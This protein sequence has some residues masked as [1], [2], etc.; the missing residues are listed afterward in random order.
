MDAN[1]R[2]G[3]VGRPGLVTAWLG[4]VARRW[5]WGFATFA[6]VMGAAVGLLFV[7]RPV[8]RAEAKLRLSDP[9]AMAGVS[10]GG[11]T[12]SL[13]RQG[14][15]PIANDMQLMKS[16]TLREQVIAENALHVSVIAPAGWHRDSLFVSLAASRDTRKATYQAAYQADGRIAVSQI[17]P[18]ETPVGTFAPGEPASFEG[19]TAVFAQRRPAAPESFEIVTTPFGDAVVALA[20]KLEASRA[21]R[22]ANVLDLKV[23][24]R[25]PK[26]AA[27]ALESMLR[28]FVASRTTL[29]QR[30]SGETVDS[31]RSVA[32]GN[33]AELA[34]AESRLEA[35][36]RESGVIAPD[37][38]ND[39]LVERYSDVVGAHETAVAERDAVTAALA[40]VQSAG[41][42]GEAWTS[43]VALPRFLENQAVGEILSQL[44]LLEQRRISLSATRT[45]DNSEYA[46]VTQQIG[47]LDASLRQLAASYLTGLN[48]QVRVLQARVDAMNDQ[49]AGVPAKV[50]EL[51]R[52]QREVRL[53]SE[54]VVLTEQRLRQEE[55]RQALTFANV[56]VID[57]PALRT[58]PVWP[59]KFWIFGGGLLLALGCGLLAM[60]VVERADGSVRSARQLALLSPPLLAALTVGRANGRP[61]AVRMTSAD[62]DLLLRRGRIDESGRSHLVILSAGLAS[63]ADVLAQSIVD[64]SLAP[65]LTHGGPNG[66]NGSNGA[67]MTS[68]LTAALT[69]MPP[70][71]SRAAAEAVATHGAPVVLV[72]R[73]GAT[74]SEDLERTLSWLS[75]ANATVVGGVLLC[76]SAREV[77]GAWS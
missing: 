55:L 50:V 21:A 66:S 59:K 17:A 67:A 41:S 60:V 18:V 45:A 27:A 46:T 76:R 68:G 10:T 58:K 7:T 42:A 24:D 54:M 52:R 40:R 63:D 15:D 25:D 33:A 53:L 62:V 6:L 14:G 19:V 22:D 72:L 75:G 39:A 49:L 51:G 30:E 44:T 2:I 20:G 3:A 4:I 23:E 28:T 16:R 37:A 74:E 61:A 1:G 65:A 36:E 69:V 11:L 32:A 43:L 48:E 26:L 13:F 9:P 71:E 77:R 57:P 56:Q 38:Q 8:Y 64:A 47:T 31:L 34:Q 12:A 73:A 29:F 35:M 70:V 5:T